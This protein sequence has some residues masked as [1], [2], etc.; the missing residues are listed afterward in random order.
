MVDLDLQQ[1]WSYWV[2]SAA[3]HGTGEGALSG[4]VASL[5]DDEQL[6]VRAHLAALPDT[7]GLIGPRTLIPVMASLRTPRHLN[8]LSAE[9]LALAILTGKWP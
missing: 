6:A 2:A 4:R 7:Y 1:E 8:F 5:P 3:K 9:A